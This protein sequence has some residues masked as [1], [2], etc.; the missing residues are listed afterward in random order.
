MRPRAAWASP[1][2]PDD[3]EICNDILRRSPYVTVLV[4]IQVW[5]LSRLPLCCRRCFQ[6]LGCVV[7]Q[8]F[9]ICCAC[10][11]L[12]SCAVLQTAKGYVLTGNLKYWVSFKF[13]AKYKKW[14][15]LVSIDMYCVCI[16][17]YLY[18]LYGA[19]GVCIGRYCKYWVCI[20]MYWFW[21]SLFSMR[22]RVQRRSTVG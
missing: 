18:V 22:V 14:Y 5:N 19:Q 9:G 1:V 8:T 2:L 16:G 11:R 12:G 21:V 20:C 10:R 6:S 7:L 4:C 15:V 13:S 17:M 3:S